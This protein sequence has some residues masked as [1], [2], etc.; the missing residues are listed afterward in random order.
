[1]EGQ[2]E[3]SS[4]QQSRQPQRR[5]TSHEE[6]QCSTEG[7]LRPRNSNQ[8]SLLVMTVA[9][10]H[11][12][13]AILMM[14][15]V[16]MVIVD[17]PA[18]ER[19]HFP[20]RYKNKE[21][22]DCT[23]KGQDVKR[24][25]C[26]TT[27][28][29]NQD[30][31]WRFCDN[32][33]KNTAVLGNASVLITKGS[34]VTLTCSS[35]ANPAVESYTWFKVDQSTPVGSGQQYSISNI[36]SEDGGQYYCEARNKFGSENSSDVSITVK[37]EQGPVTVAVVA[38]LVCAVV[39]LLCV[40]FWLRYTGKCKKTQTTGN[41]DT[42][43]SNTASM[44]SGRSRAAG[45]SSADTAGDEDPYYSTI[46]P[47]CSRDATAGADVVAQYSTVQPH[48]SR[49]ATA[50]ADV[51]AQYSTVQ[52]HCFRQTAGGAEDDFQYSVIQP[53]NLGQT[54]GAHGD[55]AHYANVQFNND[56]A[57]KSYPL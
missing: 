45:A 44:R 18:P 22:T 57:V 25:W 50:G 5:G 54:T 39:C 24:L 6:I 9:T 36:S 3:K 21:Y 48:C 2:R 13:F 49:D 30:K 12:T 28:D 23:D 53:H 19:C 14:L 27:Y 51:V 16:S 17:L 29:Y 52:P 42:V 20:F 4:R 41:G 55:D 15:K 40:L 56:G 8:D 10:S 7:R 35:D 47:N 37:G 43:Q 32:P 1:M 38:V 46:K 33:P 26:S 34:S 11:I 31:K